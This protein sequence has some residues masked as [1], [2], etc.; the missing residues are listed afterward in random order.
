MN[1]QISEK[2]Y[3]EMRKVTALSFYD[4]TDFA[5][6]SGCILLVGQNNHQ[7]R[8]SLLVNEILPPE[9]G[10]FAEQGR[11]ALTFSHRYLRRA[12]LRVRELGLAGFLTVHTHPLSDERVGFSGYDDAND[13]DL[14]RN[15]YELQPT[16]IFGSLVLGKQAIS[17]RIWLPETITPKPLGEMVIIGEQLRFI[18][19]DGNGEG[20]APPL[21]SEIFD[22]SLAITG[23][24]ALSRLSKMRVAVVGA[25]GTGSIVAELLLR[26]GVG[27]IVLFEFDRMADVNL[28]RVLHSRRQDAA[29]QVN[30]AERIA[31]ALRETE[32]P[33]RITVIKDG[34]IRKAEVAQELRGCDFIFGCVD[35][36]D[37]ARLVM[38][39]VCYQYMIPLI[40]LG[41]EISIGD[42]GIQSVDARVSYIA[43]E[44]ACL[45][46]SGIVS[47]ERVRIEGLS[48]DE[49]SRVLAMGYSQDVKLNAPAV[50]DLNMR[51]ASLAAL[52]L[53]HLLQ[54]FMDSPLPTHIKEAVTNLSIRKV[55]AT[56]SEHCNVCGIDGRTG[57]GDSIRLTVF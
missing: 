54:P 10:D 57:F 19:L 17:G 23:A 52:V 43:P 51:A 15:L 11:Y 56:K 39:Q 3:R 55:S 37:W 18:S 29:G 49:K 44:R 26:A 9:E 24:G 4:E 31:E 22:R 53:R 5:P 6:E 33:S 13:P 32:L 16:G 8:P 42:A 14:M 1:L 12:L 47:E 7:E 30:K 25:S 35:N 27:E 48:G 20:N 34:D 50:M 45:I 46:C 2:L 38:T 40:D 21:P 41:T 28:N 36:T